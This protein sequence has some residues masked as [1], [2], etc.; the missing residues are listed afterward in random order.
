[1]V[2]TNESAQDFTVFS[3]RAAQ[4]WG[5]DVDVAAAGVDGLSQCCSVPCALEPVRFNLF[6]D[7]R[8]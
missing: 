5:A 6:K 3:E 2:R 1:M 4:P 8:G 7:K